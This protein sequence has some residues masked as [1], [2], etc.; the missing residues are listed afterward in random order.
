MKQSLFIC[1]LFFSNILSQNVIGEEL[2]GQDLIDYLVDNYKTNNTLGYNNARDIM[3]EYIDIHGNNQLSCIYSGY[4]I[5]LDL[6]QDPSTNAYEQG[7]NCEHSWP[8]SLGS[9]SEPQ[10]SDMHHLFPCKSNVNSSR[11]NDP[12]AEIN[13]SSTDI[14]YRNDYSQSYVPSS[15]IEEYAEKYNPPNQNDERFEPRD[16]NKGNVARALIYFY[17]MYRDNAD[18]SFWN[19]QNDVLLLWS[20]A[21]LPDGDEINRTNMIASYQD[22]KVNPFVVDISLSQRA[23]AVT[24]PIMYGDTNGD[25]EIDV[26][27]I[28]HI[29]NFIL[30]IDTLNINQQVASDANYDIV[31]DVL[32]VIALVQRVLD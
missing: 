14:W 15:Y 26:I 3:Y 2:Y 7:I 20:N 24:E 17:T 30:D 16:E 11:G 12:Y 23:Y 21:D 25:G 9:G 28:V 29:I 32:D 19:L 6:T 27:D 1:I 13:D 4:T 5:V 8:Q 18:Q 31:V 10:K 22:Q